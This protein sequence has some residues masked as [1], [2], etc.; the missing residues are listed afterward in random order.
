[1]KKSLI[2]NTDCANEKCIILCNVSRLFST[3]FIIWCIHEIWRNFIRWY[4]IVLVTISSLLL[5]HVDPLVSEI[6][7]EEDL[8]TC[9]YRKFHGRS[10]YA[11]KEYGIQCCQLFQE[12]K[13]GIYFRIIC[14]FYYLKPFF[15][16]DCNDFT[17]TSK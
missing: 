5:N 6:R 16:K 13:P 9:L 15:R 14:V 2:S 7:P 3:S 1:M 12:F 4:C 8:A 10:S 11:T 17:T